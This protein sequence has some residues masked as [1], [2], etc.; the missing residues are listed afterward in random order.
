MDK[1]VWIVDQGEYSD[2]SVAWIFSTEEKA[3]HFCEKFPNCSYHESVLDVELPEGNQYYVHVSTDFT[4]VSWSEI[5]KRRLLH[6]NWIES[7][8][9]GEWIHI[10]VRASSPES[11]RKVAIDTAR[12]NAHLFINDT[13]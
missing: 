2:Y 8:K 1:T 6:K 3:K 7:I 11:A 13:P 9:K 10:Y 5:K 4:I 12:A